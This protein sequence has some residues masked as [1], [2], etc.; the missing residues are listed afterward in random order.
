MRLGANVRTVMAA[1]AMAVN[2]NRETND[3]AVKVVQDTF[4]YCPRL[5]KACLALLVGGV[6]TWPNMH[7]GS[8]HMHQ[9]HASE[10]R[11]FAG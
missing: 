6:P 3:D 7:I 11:S 8:W 4:D 2:K 5:D 1:L 9:P 10:S